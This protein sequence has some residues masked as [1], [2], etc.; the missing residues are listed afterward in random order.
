LEEALYV[1]VFIEEMDIKD[2]TEFMEATTQKRIDR[3]MANLCAGSCNHL[4]AFTR[5]LDALQ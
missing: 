5:A 1:G 2:L 3:V 4:E